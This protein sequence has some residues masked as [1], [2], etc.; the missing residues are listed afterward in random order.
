MPKVYESAII[1]APREKVWERIRDFNA[2]PAWHP[3]IATSELE[4]GDCIGCVRH[5]TLQDGAELREQLLT[6]SDIDCMCDY[7]M[8]E[9]PMPLKNYVAT[10]KLYK[11]TAT[12]QTFGEWY[13]YFDMTEPSAEDGTVATVHEVFRSGFESLIKYFA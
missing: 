6:L 11:I 10:L 7:G 1:N 13:A 5:F 2:L 12:N 4:Q 9:S 8:V 3:M